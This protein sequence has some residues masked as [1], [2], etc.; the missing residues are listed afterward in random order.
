[1]RNYTKLFGA[2][3]AASAL[4]AGN[5]SADVEGNIFTGEVHV[6]YASMYEFR[7]VDNGDNL[8]ETGLDLKASYWG[9][10]WSAGAW[11]GSVTDNKYDFNELDLYAGASYTFLE[12]FTVSAGY[13]YY[14]Y[15][16]STFS[17]TQEIYLG[18]SVDVWQGITVGATFYWDVDAN[19]GYYIEPTVSKSFVLVD[20]CLSLNLTAGIGYADGLASQISSHNFTGTADGYQGYYLSAALPY[21]FRENV[22]LTPYVKYTDADSKL[23]T[24]VNSRGQQFLIGGVTLAVS[25]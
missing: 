22:T 3:A 6:G 5:A 11:Y 8:V 20:P 12:K 7:F 14:N 15:Q 23:E 18:A 21:K 13:K 16:D 4:A 17:N 24:G 2:L 19:S 25:F 1:M 10:N 9:L